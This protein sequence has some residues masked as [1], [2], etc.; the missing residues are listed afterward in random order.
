M[1]IQ[2]A[3]ED[4]CSPSPVADSCSDVLSASIKSPSTPSTAS[5]VPTNGVDSISQL[6]NHSSA[7]HNPQKRASNAFTEYSNV[8]DASFKADSVSMASRTSRSSRFVR[9]L[10]VRKSKASAWLSS[11]LRKHQRGNDLSATFNLLD[12]ESKV[13]LVKFDHN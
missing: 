3:N 8:G 4:D 1:E 7:T 5:P 12:Q 6:T 10:S 13:S 2:T 11:K 9:K